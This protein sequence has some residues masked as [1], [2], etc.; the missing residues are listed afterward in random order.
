MAWCFSSFCNPRRLKLLRSPTHPLALPITPDQRQI[1][2]PC[3]QGECLRERAI[4]SGI[5]HKEV[6]LLVDY[7][8]DILLYMESVFRGMSR[9][10]GVGY[11]RMWQ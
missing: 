5:V 1:A 7:L 4:K 3:Q 8:V 9:K 2:L 10:A 11:I 6:P